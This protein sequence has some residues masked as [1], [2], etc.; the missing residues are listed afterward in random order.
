MPTKIK[1]QPQKAAPEKPKTVIEQI[2]DLVD[3]HIAVTDAILKDYS[4]ATEE[5]M[6]LELKTANENLK[7]AV[8]EFTDVEPE[9]LEFKELVKKVS[10]HDD[11]EADSIIDL[12]GGADL[13]GADERLL[14]LID[15]GAVEDHFIGQGYAWVN[16]N[17]SMVLRDKL[18]MFLKT[19]IYP[20][21][22]DQDSYITI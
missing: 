12:L 22:H 4:Y 17:G 11:F 9:E 19:E 2:I 10:E 5:D 3:K 15:T 20:Y 8:E 1:P 13:E 7:I 14:K 16:L 18:E 21:P 6:D